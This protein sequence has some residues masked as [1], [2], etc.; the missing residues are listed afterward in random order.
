MELYYYLFSK[1]TNTDFF[2]QSC[3]LLKNLY[4]F[5]LNHAG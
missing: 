5:A 3:H 1:K 4:F 2:F